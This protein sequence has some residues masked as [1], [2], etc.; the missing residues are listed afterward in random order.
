[1]KVTQVDNITDI[2]NVKYFVDTNLSA[3]GELNKLNIS[4]LPESSIGIR[5]E[6]EGL[7]K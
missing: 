2:S 3:I 6:Y 7:K 1:M 5:R 4:R